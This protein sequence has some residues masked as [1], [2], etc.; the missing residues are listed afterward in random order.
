MNQP[1][2]QEEQAKSK[3]PHQQP[4]NVTPRPGKKTQ[5]QSKKVSK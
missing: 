2:K 5:T 3:Y 4:F 1:T